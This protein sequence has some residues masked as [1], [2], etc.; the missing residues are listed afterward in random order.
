MKF[1]ITLASAVA[2]GSLLA[3]PAEAAHRHVV[4][5]HHHYHHH[6]AYRHRHYA[7]GGPYGYPP[8]PYY[9]AP[10]A[11]FYGYANPPVYNSGPQYGPYP[12]SW[13]YRNT[14]NLMLNLEGDRPFA[15]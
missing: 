10:P 8:G 12:W 7:Y 6:Y 1:F 15:D 2:L 3:L 9:Y 4:H 5:L 14:L 13:G 11:P